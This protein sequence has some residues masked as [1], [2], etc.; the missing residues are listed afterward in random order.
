MEAIASLSPSYPY[1]VVRVSDFSLSLAL[2]CCV[3]SISSNPQTVLFVPLRYNI[4]IEAPF[5]LFLGFFWL[6]SSSTR[7]LSLLQNLGFLGPSSFPLSS[8]HGSSRRHPTPISTTTT[9]YFY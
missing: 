5:T 8:S 7:S 4:L 9:F 2:L 1:L 6:P 3:L